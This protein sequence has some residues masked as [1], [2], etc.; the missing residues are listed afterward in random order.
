MKIIFFGS[1]EYCLPVLEI[2]Y[3]NFKVQA[4]VTSPVASSL[5]EKFALENGIPVFAP[6][7]KNELLSMKNKIT[8]LSPD[9]A[10]VADFGLIIPQE[11]FTLPK[12]KTLNIHFSKLP[13][14][15]GPSPVQFT[16]LLG[17]KSSWI[18]VLIMDNKVD[19]G[20]IIWQK[21]FD[22]AQGKEDKNETTES[23][24]K[25]LFRVTAQSL[26]DVI[27]LYLQGKLT[28]Q[29]QDHSKA[30]YTKLLTR[31]DG[32]VPFKDLTD[33]KK[34]VK[35]ERMI[36]AFSPWPGVWTEIKLKTKNLRLKI[37][38]AHL[39]PTTYYL[40][41]DTVQLEGKKPVSFSQFKSA[42]MKTLDK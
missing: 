18:T 9:L 32:F 10:I 28:P 34:A 39:L 3:K 27:S 29:K 17:E 13:E 41:L 16:I 7:D 23:L 1:S 15:R 30:T 19:T 12:H 42:Y 20:D 36:R 21:P 22:F 11:I 14:L 37:L 40:Q 6:K 25:K 24:Y 38:K 33:V 26:P 2:L 31:N 4:V 35:I 8:Q 5:P